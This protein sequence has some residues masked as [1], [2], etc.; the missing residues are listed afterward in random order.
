MLYRNKFRSWR[1]KGRSNRRSPPSRKRRS[2]IDGFAKVE[3]TT[4]MAAFRNTPQYQAAT[5]PTTSEARPG[6]RAHSRTARR[7]SMFHFDFTLP[8]LDGKKVSL[9][10]FKGKVVLVD[11]WGTWC[12]PCR[13]AILS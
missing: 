5:R 9:R 10:D 6:A 12:G 2:G 3:S 8:D 13:E 11:Y 7:R 4:A 1:D